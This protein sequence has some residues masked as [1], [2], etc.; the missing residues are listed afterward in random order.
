MT[1]MSN[2][3][4]MLIYIVTSVAGLVFLKISDGKLLSYQGAVGIFLYGIGFVIWYLIL[5]RV[6]LSIA[7]PI[8]AGGLVVATQIAGYF[9][10]KESLS[11]SLLLGV[12]LIITGI[13]FVASGETHL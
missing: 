12:L 8:A 13:Y 5:T 11:L 6:A 1:I 2:G 4:I 9:I 10:L 3:L 7:F